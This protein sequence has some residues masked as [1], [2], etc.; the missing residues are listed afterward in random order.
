MTIL[1][2]DHVQIA[3]PAGEEEKARAFYI[4]LLGFVEIP[5]RPNLQARRRMVPVTDCALHLGVEVDFSL[6]QGHPAFIVS[7]LDSLIAKVQ[8]AGYETIHPAAFDGLSARMFLIRLGSG[9]NVWRSLTTPQVT[10][11]ADPFPPTQS[12]L[13]GLMSDEGLSPYSWSNGPHDDFRHTHSYNKV[14]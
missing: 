12:T 9:L 3:M 6:P 11:W 5:N 13:W 8:E 7:D 1:S 14:I 4:N 2:I 10:P